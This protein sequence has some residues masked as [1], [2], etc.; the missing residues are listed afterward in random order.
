VWETRRER[1]ERRFEVK[2][3]IRYVSPKI[4]GSA[5]VHPC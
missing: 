4:V 3:K 5:V 2:R 1:A